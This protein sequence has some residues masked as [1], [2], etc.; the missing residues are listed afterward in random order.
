MSLRLGAFCALTYLTLFRWL[1]VN[2][3][4]VRQ[5][6]ADTISIGV[7]SP[8]YTYAFV[9]EVQNLPAALIEP[10]SADFEVAMSRGSVYFDFNIFVLVSRTDPKSAQATLDGFISGYGP[11]SIPRA[12]YD[13][14]DLG[15]GP[16]VDATLHAMRGYGGSLESYGVPHL[17]AVLQ[18]RVLISN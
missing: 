4:D 11:D 16:N 6:I 5:G 13:K 1:K 10:A 12:I 17:G 7:S 8:I 2:I 15:L 18:V 3:S 9:E 14:D